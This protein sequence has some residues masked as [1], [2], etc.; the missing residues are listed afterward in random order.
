MERTQTMRRSLL[1]ALVAVASAGI[2]SGGWAQDPIGQ[3]TLTDRGPRFLMATARETV[4]L[5]VSRTPV[6]RRRVSIDMRQAPLRTALDAIARQAGL[7]L[8]FSPDIVNIEALVTLE[9]KNLTVAAALTEVLIGMRLD[10]VLSPSGQLSLVRQPRPQAVGVVTGRVTDSTANEGIAGVRVSVDGTRLAATTGLNGN[11]TV[12]GVLAGSRTITARKLGYRTHSRTVPVADNGTANVDFVLAHAP[13]VLSEI[14]VTPTGDRQRFEVGNA[15]GTIRADS[16]V[17]MMLIRNMS[18][19]LTARMPGVVVSNTTGAVGAPSKVRVRGINSI[20]LNNDPIIILDGMR[21]NATVTVAASQMNIGEGVIPVARSVSNR[22]SLGSPTPS[23]LDDID[24]NTIESI[25]IL[26]GPSAASLYGT[27]AANGVIVIKTK[28]GKAA[29]RLRYSL[30]ADHGWSRPAGRFVEP[31]MSWG[32]WPNGNSGDGCFLWVAAS[33]GCRLDSLSH[34]NPAN[35]PQMT[36]VGVGTAKNVSASLSGGTEHLSE[37]VSLRYSDNVGMTKMSAVEQR[38]IARMWS[39]PVPFWMRRPNTSMDVNGS[40]RTNF[41]VGPKLKVA[42]SANGVYRDVLSGSSGL[43]RSTFSLGNNVALGSWDTLRYLPSERQRGKQSSL[44]KRAFV[45]ANANYVPTPWLSFRGTVGGDYTLRTHESLVRATEC[46]VELAPLTGCVSGRITDRAETWMTTMDLGA[47][48]TFTPR[49]W[50]TTRTA[51]GEQFNST[52]FYSL[53]AGNNNFSTNLG[54]GTELLTPTP[55]PTSGSPQVFEITESRDEAATAGWYLEQMA[56]IRERLFITA[57]LRQDAASAFG[58]TVNRNLPVYPKFSLSWLVSNE[59]FFPFQNLISSLRLRT[60]YGHSG[61][62]ASQTAVLANYIQGS[63]VINGIISPAIVQNSIG[64][65]D[66]KPERSTEWEGGFDLSM[67]SNERVHVEASLYRKLSRDA[68]VSIPLPA[69]YGTMPRL[70]QWFSQS[71]LRNIGSVENRGVEVSVA[72]KLLDARSFGWDLQVSMAQNKNKLVSSGITDEFFQTRGF[73]VGY[74]IFAGFGRAVASYADADGDG[75]ISRDE[76]VMSAG[77]PGVPRSLTYVGAP[78]PRS[79]VTWDNGFTFLSGAFRL[80]AKIDQVNGLTQRAAENGGLIIQRCSSD[81]TCTLAQQA[82]AVGWS[83]GS[84]GPEGVEATVIRLS[85]LSATYRLPL[86]IAKRYLRAQ[87]AQATLAGRNLGV[88]SNYLW[89][90]PNLDSFV[91]PTMTETAVDDGSAIA[92]PR[93][94]TVRIQ[95][96]F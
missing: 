17:S 90:D 47:Q 42:L 93:S 63:A 11:Y 54:F 22:N 87:G 6:L 68:I 48:F 32:A 28:Q 67:F 36:T 44:A 29:S 34:F 64:N 15:I 39:S 76:I 26:R 94:W 84:F 37:Y 58:A 2:A 79:E 10:V 83:M 46:T 18:D 45:S 31:W 69:S 33:G 82:A 86:A 43:S 20:S 62:Q 92:Q 77:S 13:T 72:A 65:P 3:S 38:R 12:R 27:E 61:N 49:P 89:G 56:G 21:L 4:E 75:I 41:T 60:A 73:V 16:V 1:A 70:V 96:E 35:D 85:E 24:P 19:L 52:K 78:Y 9:A 66:L 57:A 53:R 7:N 8:T 23:R 25:D 95:V 50:L 88:W 71:Q 51:V 30:L 55:V 59:P 40:S 14:V 91:S 74:P 81:K 5:D 80:G